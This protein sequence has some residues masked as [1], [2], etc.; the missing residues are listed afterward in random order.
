MKMAL[1]P[2]FRRLFSSL[3]GHEE[4]VFTRQLQES[5]APKELGVWYLAGRGCMTLTQEHS[6]PCEAT[7]TQLIPASIQQQ[8]GTELGNIWG[9]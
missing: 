5:A 7:Q 1:Q 9:T 8:V 6:V 3:R 4:N 2:W